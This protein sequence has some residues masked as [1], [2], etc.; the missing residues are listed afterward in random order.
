[1][2]KIKAW[3]AD[4][5]LLA[6]TAVWGATFPLVKTS[7]ELMPTYA[8]LALRFDLGALVLLL[9]TWRR[10]ARAPK[11]TWLAGG[12]IGL[13]LFSGY[14]FQ[15][16]GLALTTSAKTGFIT[17]LSVVLVPLISLLWLKKAPSTGAWLGVAAATLGLALMTLEGNLMPGK[18]DLLVLVCALSFAL[19]IITVAR[20]SGSHDPL[21]LTFIQVATVALLC[22]LFSAATEPFPAVIPG[23]AWWGIVICG[24]FATALAFLLQNALQ[25]RTTATHT[26]L[27][28]SA[29]PV[30]AAIFAWLLAGEVLTWRTL[31]GGG[32]ILAGMLLAELPVKFSLRPAEQPPC[33]VPK[34]RRPNW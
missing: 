28:F 4:L 14:V 3:Q 23:Y 10:L 22:H 6:V 9:F 29:E 16:F 17:G 7:T 2:T 30:W 1:V 21:A 31:F 18:G 27:I 13:F 32:L 26:A 34:Q 11:Q 5:L 24:L 33:A 12:L 20:F 19:H 25:P 15:T 8:F